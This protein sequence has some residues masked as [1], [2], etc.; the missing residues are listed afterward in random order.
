MNTSTSSSRTPLMNMPPKSS[1]SENTSDSES[2]IVHVLICIRCGLY[3]Y[4][5]IYIYIYHLCII[6]S[7]SYMHVILFSL[8]N[9][10]AAKDGAQNQQEFGKAC[11]EYTNTN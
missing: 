1:R 4:I 2:M 9:E 8:F 5:Y 7:L 11:K 10:S 6:C 3:I